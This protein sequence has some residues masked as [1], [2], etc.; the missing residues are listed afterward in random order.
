MR[1]L[2]A[3]CL[4]LAPAAALATPAMTDRPTVMRAAPSNHARVL[5]SIPANAQIDVEGCGQY[6]CNASWRDIS[7]F[8][9]VNVI[10]G[11]GPPVYRPAPPPV[12]F[13]PPVVVAPFGFG[14]G[15]GWRHHYY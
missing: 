10:S 7:G 3:A 12:V 5:Q 14:F 1:R 13:G 11:G 6:W 9:S 8:V 4:I 2:L 15:Y